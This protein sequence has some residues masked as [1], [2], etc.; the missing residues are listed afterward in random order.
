MLDLLI[1]PLEA[2]AASL[3]CFLVYRVAKLTKTHETKWQ[4]EQ[5]ERALKEEPIKNDTPIVIP[6][7]KRVKENYEDKME[8]LKMAQVFAGAQM[9][10]VK[11]NLGDLQEENLSWLREAISL[12]LIGAVDFIGKQTN[13]GAK[14]RK[15][16]IQLVLKSNLQVSRENASV[17]FSEALNRQP[18]SDN[19]HMVRAGARAAKIW[20]KQEA[21]PSNFSLRTQLDDWGVFA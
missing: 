6:K 1:H 10:E 5:V 2:T 9:V 4:H 11:R 19:D 7:P 17:Y 8:S 12:Y 16:L 15:E 21:V 3:T 18:Q 13:C 14:S 20:L